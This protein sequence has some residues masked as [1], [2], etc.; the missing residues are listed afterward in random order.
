MIEKATKLFV[1]LLKEMSLEDDYEVVASSEVHDGP[2]D[3]DTFQVEDDICP[4]PVPGFTGCTEEYYVKFKEGEQAGKIF[5]IE[6]I[7]DQTQYG[8][9]DQIQLKELLSGIDGEID[10]LKHIKINAF[11]IYE[12]QIPV[13]ANCPSISWQLIS[14]S[15]NY[16]ARTTSAI[17][18]IRA[19][20]KN[21][22]NLIGKFSALLAGLNKYNVKKYG[23]R[24]I[25][26]RPFNISSEYVHDRNAHS[27]RADIEIKYLEEE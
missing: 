25:F 2:V 20:D 12:A 11:T 16:R 5:Q 3:D 13:N 4:D 1:S 22:S 10:V 23:V 24:L 6:A 17:Y 21:K 14:G 27:M 19:T 9:Y 15:D 26:T 7:A 8:Y 18:Q